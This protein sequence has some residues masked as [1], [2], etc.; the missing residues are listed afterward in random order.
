MSRQGPL[1]FNANDHPVRFTWYPSPNVC[2]ELSFSSDI[3]T[4]SRFILNYKRLRYN[5]VW[6]EFPDVEA[7][8]R[9]IGAPPSA[10]RADGKPIYTLPVIVDPT[11]NPQGPAD[12]L[13]HQQHRRIP[14]S[15]L[16]RTPGLP[17]GLAR[18]ADALRALHPGGVREAAATHHGPQR[19]HAWQ[20]VKEQFDFLALILDKNVGDGSSDG[21]VAQGCNASWHLMTGGRAYEIGMGDAGLS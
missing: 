16:S 2:E 20:L 4:C 9:G 10:K 6:I 18:P 8:L 15:V 12:P 19:E 14:R 5:T 21:I 3:E 1:P 7:T 11:R 17:R 13:K